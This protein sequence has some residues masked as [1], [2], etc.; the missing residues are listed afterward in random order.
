MSATAVPQSRTTELWQI[1]PTHSHVE[2]AVRHMMISSVKGRFGEITGTVRVSDGDPRSAV[3]DVEIATGSIDTRQEQRDAHLRSADFLDVERFPTLTFHSTTVEP[4]GDELR[5]TGDLTLHGVTR[6]VTL[7][8]TQEGRTRDPW[9][10]ER[11]GFSATARLK[12]SDFGLTWNQALETGG[13]VVDD[14]IRITIDA[15]LVRQ[16]D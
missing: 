4:D 1:D 15:E 16:D 7:T 13:F 5:I 2:F 10:K 6:P 14:T 9:G 3:V 12:R 11:A 8:A